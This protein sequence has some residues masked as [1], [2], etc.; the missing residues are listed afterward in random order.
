[1]GGARGIGLLDRRVRLV[2]HLAWLSQV[3]VAG[4]LS[5]FSSGGGWNCGEYAITLL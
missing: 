1:M 2:G 4:G 3:R 5:G